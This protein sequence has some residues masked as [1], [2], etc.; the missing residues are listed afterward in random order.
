MALRGFRRQGI[1]PYTVETD[2]LGKEIETYGRGRVTPKA[3]K[4]TSSATSDTTTQYGD[5]GIAEE[6]VSQGNG[7]LTLDLT[8]L[9]LE[10]QA[11]IMGHTYVGEENHIVCNEGDKA[12]YCICSSIVPGVLNKKPYF[13]VSTYLRVSFAPVNDD[14]ETKGQQ[15]V[16]KGA[17][18]SGSFYPNKNGD[19]KDIREFEKFEDAL[20][21]FDQMLHITEADELK[22]EAAQPVETAW[23]AQGVV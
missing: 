13:R 16:F 2:A 18:L 7:S 17:S 14:F 20:K 6:E 8:N 12:P 4:L 15:V 19:W 21:Y 23:K 9:T 5:D 11:E 10:D 3:M 22:A 1:C